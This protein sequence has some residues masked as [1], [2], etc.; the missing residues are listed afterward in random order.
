[1]DKPL[2]RKLSAILYADV[3]D[4]SRLMG[5]DEERTHRDLSAGL[6]LLINLINEHGGR[7]VHEA[8]DA[9]LA[10]FPSAKAAVECAVAFQRQMADDLHGVPEDRRLQFRVGINLGDVIHDRDDIYG[11]GVNVAARLESIAETGGICISHPVFLQVRGNHEIGFEYIGEQSVKNIEMPIVTYRILL[12]SEQAGKLHG[13]VKNKPYRLTWITAALAAILI[14]GL[15][16]ARPWAPEFEPALESQMQIALPD[17]PSLVVL[18]FSNIS[19]DREQEYF[20]DGMTDDLLTG[21]SKMPELFVISSNTSFSYKNKAVKVRD[22]AEELG[23][24][25]VLEGSVRRAGDTV[26]INAQLIDALSGFHVWAEKYDGKIDDVFQLQDEVVARIISSLV[27]NLIPASRFAETNVPEAYDQLLQGM[28]FFRMLDPASTVTAIEFFNRATE[29]DPKFHRAYAAL[30]AAYFRIADNSWSVKTGM[31]FNNVLNLMK[32]NLAI[33]LE[34]PTSLA[35]NVSAVW[36]LWNGEH[37]KA[38]AEI[39]RAI[40]LNPN[41]AENFNTKAYI[42]VFTGPARQIEENARHAMRLNPNFPAAYLRNLGEGLFH[43]ERY[44]EAAELFER[45][46]NREPNYEYNYPMLAA[47]YGHLEN[48]ASAEK[49]HRE[50][51]ELRS[52][53][54]GGA[55]TV[56]SRSLWIPYAE[57]S[58]LLRYQQG[59]RLAGV[60]E[61][62][63]ADNTEINYLDLVTKAEGEYSVEGAIKISLV[64]AEKLHK[65]GYAFID[66]RATGGYVE[67]H[68][69]GAI[70][71]PFKTGLTRGNLQKLVSKSEPAVFYC[72]GEG[73]YKSA[74]GSAK[75][76]TWGYTK[77]YYF[78]VGMPAWEKAGLHVEK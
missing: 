67:G 2:P 53:Q 40:A 8:G 78:A 10:D 70:S 62:I 24:R 11:D 12:E 59:L 77:V 39:D 32:Q 69:P 15:L 20:A 18:P 34:D 23:V 7:K 44:S 47:I 29:L 33:A 49:A 38:L 46:A 4:Y 27:Q 22:V 75:A 6:N 71:L 76:I 25:Y 26:R 61:G 1:L 30:A 37:E 35:L 72:D 21:L 57:E 64:E 16:I 31:E 19:D 41:D 28:E 17:N 14:A 5:E 63:I 50:F 73:C 52:D 43:Q 36:K 51:L 13:Q 56:Q 65:Q 66:N 9:V 48:L 74:H 58:H 42:Q 60:P 54:E 3:A 45:A 55:F 68:I